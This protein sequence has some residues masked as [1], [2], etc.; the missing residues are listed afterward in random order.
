[1]RIVRLA[2]IPFVT[3][4]I[5]SLMSVSPASASEWATQSVPLPASTEGQTGLYKGLAC[6]AADACLAAGVVRDNSHLLKP[7]VM[8]RSG[9][10]WAELPV[11]SR[12]GGWQP[13]D[14]FCAPKTLCMLIGYDIHEGISTP[15]SGVA[16]M[17]TSG[18]RFVNVA[19]G[20]KNFFLS[21]GACA[22]VNFCMVVGSADGRS[23]ASRWDGTKWTPTAVG[24]NKS[25]DLVS[26]TSS[27]YCMAVGTVGGASYKTLNVWRGQ[28]W[29]TTG[30][31][32]L[33]GRGGSLTSLSCATP[34]FCTAVGSSS[35]GG[36]I[37]RQANGRNAFMTVPAGVLSLNGVSCPSATFC[38]AAGQAPDPL[39]NRGRAAL[40]EWTVGN[41]W[42]KVAFSEPDTIL[43][44]VACQ[45]GTTACTA[46]GTGD[47]LLAVA[48]G[49]GVPATPR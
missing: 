48:R 35:S 15:S 38:A 17:H 42:A 31:I 19:P 8:R 32:S 7:Y 14:L 34:T 20:K 2:A 23:L 46:V 29:V 4:L 49:S 11:P 24:S 21:R 44:N 5:A 26:C 28:S 45:T 41:P 12:A 47:P 3:L 18:W 1:M 9:G 40:L 33:P 37:W 25:L 30:H 43:F 22:A 36:V 16:A 39:A 13:T 27:T 10:R 6:P